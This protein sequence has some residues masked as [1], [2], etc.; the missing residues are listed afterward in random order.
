MAT[1]LPVSGSGVVINL[2][3]PGLCKTELIPNLGPV[4]KS[5]VKLLRF[6]LA[7][8]SEEGSRNLLHA[9]M[10]GEESRGKYLSQ[11]DIKEHWFAPFVTNWKG[12]NMQEKVWT[13]LQAGLET[14]E[15]GCVTKALR[16]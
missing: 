7:R 5:A 13:Q 2:L 16:L 6:F 14:I 8:T 9:A 1:K 12:Q 4:Y 11:C 10:S 15:A 3:D